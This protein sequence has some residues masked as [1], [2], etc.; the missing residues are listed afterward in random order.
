MRQ[1]SLI[2]LLLAATGLKAQSIPDKE[3]S[4]EEA[5]A[6]VAKE[7]ASKYLFL[8]VETDPVLT[9]YCKSQFEELLKK[10]VEELQF[11]AD[12]NGVVKLKLLFRLNEN[13][14]LKALGAKGLVLSPAQ[15]D[16]L[17]SVFN[18]IDQIEYGRQK[19]QAVNC[20]GILYMVISAGKLESFRNVNFGFN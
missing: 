14:C 10:L 16:Q 9:E 6:C 3:F 11:G 7:Q 13:V 5:A 17:Y 2:L 8:K 1:I 19:N 18:G 15:K 20:Q 12:H 4:W